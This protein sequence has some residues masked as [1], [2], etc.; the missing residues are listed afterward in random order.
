MYCLPCKSVVEKQLKVESGIQRIDVDYVTDNVAV[1]LVYGAVFSIFGGPVGFVS[2]GRG[3]FISLA[4]AGML[5]FF[6]CS[7]EVSI[8]VA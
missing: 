3:D 6:F 5:P 7:S 4:I 2:G 8:I 1:E